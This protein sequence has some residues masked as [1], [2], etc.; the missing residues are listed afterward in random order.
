MTKPQAGFT[1]LELV[2]A[3]AIFALLGVACWRLFDGVLRAERS[4]SAHEQTLRGLQRAVALIER[5][6]LHLHTS[7]KAPGLALYP[8]QLN[9]RRA[10]WRNPLGQ[11]RSELQDVSYTL[12]NGE[13]WRYS[14]GLEGG[15]LQKQKLLTDVRDLRWR[16]YD[17][18]LGWRTDWPTGKAAPKGT[19][20]AL[21]VQFSAGRFEQLRRVMLLPEGQ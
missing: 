1:L 3:I 5:D 17:P 8:S 10:N 21:E 7:A 19:P 6:V 11:P 12:E 20:R 13:L 4:S 14:Q 18:A 15:A 2:I 9:L 16:L